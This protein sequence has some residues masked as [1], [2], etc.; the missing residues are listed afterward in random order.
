MEASISEERADTVRNGEEWDP[1]KCKKQEERVETDKNPPGPG[2]GF[3]PTGA[4]LQSDAPTESAKSGISLE[5]APKPLAWILARPYRRYHRDLGKVDSQRLVVNQ[6]G[7]EIV[8]GHKMAGFEPGT[9]WFR[10]ECS[11]VTTRDPTGWRRAE[12]QLGSVTSSETQPAALSPVPITA[13]TSAARPAVN[14]SVSDMRESEEKPLIRDDLCDTPARDT[15][16][17]PRW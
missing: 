16:A 5:S 14:Q 15:A 6:I 1:C 4:S 8:Q 9:S 12:Y 17:S 13:V 2:P 3:E 7:G 10:D 11:A